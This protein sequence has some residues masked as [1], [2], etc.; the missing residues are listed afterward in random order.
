MFGE[1]LLAC[2]D[3]DM[4]SFLQKCLKENWFRDVTFTNKDGKELEAII[5]KRKPTL[6]LL[7]SRH[8][9]GCT[10]FMMGE[11]KKKF[12]WL[13]IA[14]FSIS[15]YAPDLARWFI[16]NGAKYYVS[17]YDG[18]DEFY[19]GLNHIRNGKDYISPKVN[20][21]RDKREEQPN[22]ARGLT[23]ASKEVA[24]CVCSGFFTKE[25]KDILKISV[26]T[27]N[28]HKREI[29]KNLNAR[30]GVELLLRVL[31]L[32]IFTLEELNSYTKNYTSSPQ[33]DK[34]LTEKNEEEQ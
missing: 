13:N 34:N 6:F 3:E 5:N 9:L 30:N 12:A 26:M 2:K 22:A 15:Y 17:F 31:T 27:I 24:R 8:S 19:K 4:Y 16:N 28:N 7:D 23:K 33:P 29:F 10:P 21:C 18:I 20:K 25:T 11:L 32:G 1:T 14:V